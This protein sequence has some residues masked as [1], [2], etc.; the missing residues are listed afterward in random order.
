MANVGSDILWNCVQS[1]SSDNTSPRFLQN[2]SVGFLVG[3]EQKL[4]GLVVLLVQPSLWV[5][6]CVDFGSGKRQ[7]TGLKSGR[8]SPRLRLVAVASGP[9]EVA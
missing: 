5:R 7:D 6:G 8:Y 9:Q 1:V 4:S 3:V 2:L